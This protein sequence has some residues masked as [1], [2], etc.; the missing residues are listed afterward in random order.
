[1]AGALP[2]SAVS[3]DFGD[4][5]ESV[6]FASAFLITFDTAADHSP[7]SSQGSL[8][9]I[10]G[11]VTISNTGVVYNYWNSLSGT[12]GNRQA[13]D[14][15]LIPGRGVLLGAGY[16]VSY[17]EIAFANGYNAVAMDIAELNNPAM[18]AFA[19]SAFVQV[20]GAG[21]TPLAGGATVTGPAPTFLAFRSEESNIRG[22]RIYS[23][24]A[25][26]RPVID[27][28]SAG[29]WSTRPDPEP[30][31]IPEPSSLTLLLVPVLFLLARNY[32]I[33]NR[34]Q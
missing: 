6:S 12:V 1:L 28:L 23:N 3:I 2:L 31:A 21:W 20:F 7:G 24:A 26:S 10:P 33:I 16:G 22:I 13:A 19:G 5:P 29:E 4:W 14:G 18:D 30:V 17:V 27:N 15:S 8:A 32:P 9:S 25:S 11:V 34:L